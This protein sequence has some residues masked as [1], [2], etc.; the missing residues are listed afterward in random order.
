MAVSTWNF[1]RIAKGKN[2][3]VTIPFTF[4]TDEE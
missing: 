1:G 4:S 2:T 3:T